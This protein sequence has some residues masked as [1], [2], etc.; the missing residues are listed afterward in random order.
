VIGFDEVHD[1]LSIP[2]LIDV[3]TAAQASRRAQVSYAFLGPEL[4]AVKEHPWGD[5]VERVVVRALSPTLVGETIA[6][7]FGA[8]GRDAGDAA[9][10]IA[11]IAAG[12]PQ[13]SNL[14]ASLLWDQTP[15]GG[16]ATITA[17]RAAID[18]AL[19]RCTP[20]FETRWAT[21]HGNERRVAVAIAN[22]IAPQGTR[23]QRATGLASFGAAQRALHGIRASGV[24][25]TRDDR[26]VLTD[27]LFAEWLRRRHAQ[28]PIEP[29]WQALR[30]ATQ[31]RRGGLSRGM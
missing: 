31:A 11:T 6:A 5:E 4:S 25:E 16:R 18:Q 17:A 19:S 28:T 21:L 8:T 26:T 10:I 20:E 12:H 22:D 29:D 23:A 27:S 24:A 9:G 7:R 13:R 2:G 3:L 14:L 30:S 15:A 1:A